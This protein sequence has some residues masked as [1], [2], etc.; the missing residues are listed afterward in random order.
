[1]D[2][3]SSLKLIAWSTISTGV[4]L[5]A[6]KTDHKKTV[7]QPGEA[8]AEPPLDRMDEEKK[9]YGQLMKERFFTSHEMATVA[10][11]CDIIIPADGVSGS[12]TDAQVPDFIEFMMKDK[13]ELQTPVRGGLRWL[14]L[15][16]MKQYGKPFSEV[17][18]Q[19]QIALVDQIAYPARARPAMQ[20]GVRFF[21]VQR[22]LT[23]CG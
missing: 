2:R 13:P 16:M 5:D 14:D 20:Q 17:S 8:I 9:A 1:M 22:N 11:L 19:Q 18:R 15:Q 10:I 7:D 6:C 3:R 23:A 4:I 12:A 21:S